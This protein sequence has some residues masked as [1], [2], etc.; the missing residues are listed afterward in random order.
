[1]KQHL[2][3]IL[4]IALLATAF[5]FFAFVDEMGLNHSPKVKSVGQQYIEQAKVENTLNDYT[6]S[7]LRYANAFN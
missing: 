6:Y 4:Y 2:H 5:T 7:P 1:M 3:E